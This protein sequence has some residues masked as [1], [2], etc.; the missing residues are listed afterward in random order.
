M[1]SKLSSISILS[2]HTD[3]LLSQQKAES[4]QKMVQKIYPDARQILE[5]MD[6]IILGS[7]P[8]S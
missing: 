2:G 7:T 5:S 1:G 4:A 8:S 3:T 6:E